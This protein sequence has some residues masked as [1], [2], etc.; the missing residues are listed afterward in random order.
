MKC[1]KTIVRPRLCGCG[2][3][4]DSQSVAAALGAR[5]SVVGIRYAWSA[6]RRSYGPRERDP[7]LEPLTGSEA[8]TYKRGWARSDARINNERT[9]E[10]AYEQNVCRQPSPQNRGGQRQPNRREDEGAEAGANRRSNSNREAGGAINTDPHRFGG[11]VGVSPHCLDA[12]SC[13]IKF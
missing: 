2:N 5:P 9:T 4:P 6:I 3:P 13:A 12:N 10:Y 1:V 11:F 7:S 8:A